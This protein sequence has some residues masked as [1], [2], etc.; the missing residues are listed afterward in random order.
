MKKFGLFFFSTFGVA[1]CLAIV[2]GLNI[3]ASFAKY[4][5]DLTAEKL[6]TLSDGTKQ[7]LQEL[8]TPVQIRFYATRDDKVMPPQFKTHVRL[9]EDLL[10][11]F[12]RS[13]DGKIKIEK[14]DPQ[15]DSDAED[16]ARLDG[17]ESQALSLTERIYLGL[18]VSM[19]DETVPIP[20]LDPSREEHLEYEI[21][22]AVSQVMTVEETVVGVMSSLPVFGANPM[23]ARMGQA[24][25]QSPWVVIEQLQQLFEVRQIEMTAE[26]IDEEV[27]VLILIHPKAITETTEYALDQFL[28]RGG[29]L[30]VFLDS[31]ALTDPQ[32]SQNN[33]MGPPPS[34]SNLPNL[35]KAW[36]L[37]FDSGKVVADL[38]FAKEISFRQGVP[39]QIQPAFLFVNDNGINRSNVVTAQIDQLWMPFAGAFSGEPLEGLE[40]TVLIQSTEQSQLVDGFMARLSGQQIARDFASDDKKRPIALRLDGKF[41][42]AFAEG[43]PKT[44]EEANAEEDI[45]KEDEEE[46]TEEESLK[47]SKE[48]GAVVL[49]GD[50]DFLADP[51]SVRVQNFLGARLISTMNGNLS[52]A[53]NLVEQLAGDNR[54]IHV[55]SRASMNRPFTRIQ[56][57]QREAE[58]K[59]RSEIRALEEK[60]QQTQTKLNELQR[61]RTDVS[62]GQRFVL[63]PEQQ[64]E[65]EKLR[66]QEV[67]TNRQL[68]KTRRDLRK[69]V[70]ALET[71]LKWINIA[72]MPIFVA[73]IGIFIAL[74][75]RIQTAAR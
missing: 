74:I 4:R 31:L 15:P 21:I 11:E 5:F 52:L 46:E 48:D 12:R 51:F 37:E 66:K 41:K 1:A 69:D 29:N 71:S 45:D 13:S 20:F 43:K 73:F 42:T 36:G 40:Q 64:A 26:S 17:V 9:V 63:S 27:T 8:D 38:S 19:L 14:F 55:R 6:F 18:A 25:R 24:Q 16:S 62:Q 58:E 44:E 61:N 60:R 2:V 53:Q 59:Y 22:R 56:E 7:I 68:K 70:D 54:L 28:L 23:M 35:L 34:T 10:D 67:E 33:M 75:K 32:P 3:I 50:A 39:A 30:L 72:F 57:K 47:E 65:L 49:F